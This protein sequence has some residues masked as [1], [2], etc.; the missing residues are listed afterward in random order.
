M[1]TDNQELQVGDL[2]EILLPEI[3]KGTTGKVQRACGLK[4]AENVVVA[5]D[6]TRFQLRIQLSRHLVRPATTKDRPSAEELV[7]LFY[8]AEVDIYEDGTDRTGECSGREG[9][10]FALRP[11]DAVSIP[12]THSGT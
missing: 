4:N 9:S 11:F 12:G 1:N 5:I 7:S 2:V 10:E 6:T 3:T 8:A